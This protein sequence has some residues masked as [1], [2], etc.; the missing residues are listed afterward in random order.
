MQGTILIQTQYFDSHWQAETRGAVVETVEL[1]LRRLPPSERGRFC[2]FASLFSR[3]AK[4]RHCI[5]TDAASVWLVFF[6]PSTLHSRALACPCPGP[7]WF[8]V[9]HRVFA[10]DLIAELL[11]ADWVWHSTAALPEAAGTEPVTPGGAGGGSAEPSAPLLMLGML[12]ARGADRAPTV[13]ARAL[14][15]LAALASAAQ[16]LDGAPPLVRALLRS[17]FAADPPPSPSERK[18]PGSAGSGES[19]SLRSIDLRALLRRRLGDERAIVRRAAAQAVAA[20]AA[21]HLAHRSVDAGGAHV[22][23]DGADADSELAREE[24][25][26]AVGAWGE[27]CAALA[28]LCA[29]VSVATRKAAAAG[30]SGLRALLPRSARLAVAWVSA[31][32]PLAHDSEVTVSGRCADLVREAIVEPVAAWPTAAAASLVWPLLAAA[33]SPEA[34]RCLQAALWPVA[35]RHPEKALSDAA[36]FAGG[37]AL[38]GRVL[39]SLR[40]AALLGCGRDPAGEF[41]A[42]AADGGPGRETVRQGAWVLLE[43]VLCPTIAGGS[44]TAPTVALTAATAPLEPAFVLA[45]WR[46]LWHEYEA[47]LDCAPSH[48]ASPEEA[49]KWASHQAGLEVDAQRMLRVV[50]VLAPAIAA[51]DASTL[52]AELLGLLQSFAATAATVT[53]EKGGIYLRNTLRTLATRDSPPSFAT[54]HLLNPQ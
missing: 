34:Q 18:T 32:L 51:A 26:A 22:M 23:A 43:A 7:R 6:D 25:D 19:R 46:D 5:E 10:V 28:T 38:H 31:V 45:C 11:K 48:E 29:D 16:N 4:A 50:T 17:Q 41:L 33:H 13:R 52:A 35:L 37:P 14:G 49:A 15:A 36:C 27:E 8:Q 53:G 20:L 54:F 40:A 3:S 30:L 21:L 2:S 12:V 1:I 39:A 47:I 9:N 44:S 24:E 42:A